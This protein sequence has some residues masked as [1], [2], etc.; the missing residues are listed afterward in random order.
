MNVCVVRKYQN[1]VLLVKNKKRGGWEFPGGKI[2]F[3]KDIVVPGIID[4]EKVA[5]REYAEETNTEDL[6][7][8]KPNRSFYNPTTQ[9]FFMVYYVDFPFHEKIIIGDKSIGKAKEFPTNKLP[10]MNFTEDIATITVI[11]ES[12]V[13]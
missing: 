10:N 6:I 13:N 8:L 3:E 9:T 4:I 5:R 1:K 11:L 12:Q 2:D 7:D